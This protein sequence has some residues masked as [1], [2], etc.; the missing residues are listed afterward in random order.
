HLLIVLRLLAAGD[1]GQAEAALLLL[2]RVLVL[3][4]LV[5]LILVLR[6]FRF[7]RIL[8]IFFFLVARREAGC[9]FDVGRDLG[10]RLGVEGDV[11]L[12]AAP[13]GRPPRGVVPPDF[14]SV[15]VQ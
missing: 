6:I 1:A 3:R 12:V 9:P 13:F 4:I 5:L 11:L 10:D 8:C 15:P 7:L 14:L 2:L